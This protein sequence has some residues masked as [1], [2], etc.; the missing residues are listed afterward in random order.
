MAAD[1]SL[2]ARVCGAKTRRGTPCRSTKLYPNGRCHNHGGP[3]TGPKTWKAGGRRSRKLAAFLGNVAERMA[4]PALLDARDKLAALDEAYEDLLER[5]LEE[6]DTPSFRDACHEK[7]KGALDLLREGDP[8][9]QP[10][11]ASLVSMLRRGVQRDRALA[12]ATALADRRISRTVDL[13]R[14]MVSEANAIGVQQFRSFAAMTFEVI[15]RAAGN[16]LGPAI[17]SS[18]IDSWHGRETPAAWREVIAEVVKEADG[19]VVDVD[20]NGNPAET[21]GEGWGGDAQPG[22]EDAEE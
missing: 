1:D 18:M 16:R 7:A 6:R 20:E 9:V 2:P 4:D 21:D 14:V 13:R 17:V 19:D 22:A 3:S 8:G 12:E 10:E 15:M 11:L 5:A